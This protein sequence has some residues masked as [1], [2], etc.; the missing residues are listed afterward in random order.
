MNQ[1][2]GMELLYK[3]SM[4]I[5]MPRFQINIARTREIRVLNINYNKG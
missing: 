1:I 2:I 5:N 3:L 4:R